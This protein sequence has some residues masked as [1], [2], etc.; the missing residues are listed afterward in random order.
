MPAR[1]DDI[2]LEQGARFRRVYQF[3]RLDLTGDV[4]RMQVRAAPGDEVLIEVSSESPLATSRIEIDVGLSSAGER[5]TTMA[6][7]IS[8]DLTAELSPGRLVYD[9][10]SMV[11]FDRLIEGKALVTE[12][13]TV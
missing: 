10:K 5:I 3:I 4:L 6:V 12:Q 11:T 2:V 1:R 13:V 8:E 9:I 7:V